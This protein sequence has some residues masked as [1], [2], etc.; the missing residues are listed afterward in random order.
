[1]QDPLYKSPMA[2]EIKMD[3]DSSPTDG[4]L[5]T[6]CQMIIASKL[7]YKLEVFMNREPMGSKHRLCESCYNQKDESDD[8][9]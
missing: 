6:E 1:M 7:M 3:W 9:R 5:C 4:S 8:D 2:I